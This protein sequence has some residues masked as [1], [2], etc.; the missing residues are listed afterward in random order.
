MMVGSVP[1]KL[2]FEV[3]INR[4][5]VVGL[6]AYNTESR[7]LTTEE[8]KPK[9]AKLVSAKGQEI[10]GPEYSTHHA[11]LGGECLMCGD[12]VLVAGKTRFNEPG[13]LVNMQH[14]CRGGGSSG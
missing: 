1:S 2:S 13:F 9:R 3:H 4:R 7:T 5:R 11:V 10:V 6:S 12:K 8:S 14:C